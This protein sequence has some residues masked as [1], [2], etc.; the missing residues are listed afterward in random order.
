MDT[1]KLTLI[2]NK[3]IDGAAEGKCHRWLNAAHLVGTPNPPLI[4]TWASAPQE[5]VQVMGEIARRWN[6]FPDVLA[7]LVG[8][9]P[10]A[11][12]H[13]DAGPHGSGWQSNEL[14]AAIQSARAAIAKATQP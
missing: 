11:E 2:D 8:I 10:F 4:Q 3:A 12:A 9:L 6:A 1:R 13:E 14:Q 7:A 5:A